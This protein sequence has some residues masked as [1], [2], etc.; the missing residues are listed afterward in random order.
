VNKAATHQPLA[1]GLHRSA[2][3][4]ELSRRNTPATAAEHAALLNRASDQRA[5]AAN[6]AVLLH[7]QRQYGNNYVNQVLQQG[8]QRSIPPS[9]PTGIQTK[10][11]IGPAGDKYEREADRVAAAVVETINTPSPPAAGVGP[12][13]RAKRNTE[14]GQQTK[15][16]ISSLQREVMPDAEELRAQMKP[17]PA[18]HKQEP[19]D[20]MLKGL[21][22]KPASPAKI[23]HKEDDESKHPIQKKSHPRASSR[24]QEDH[25]EDNV[26]QLQP[27]ARNP[28]V[29]GLGEAPLDLETSI[30]DV[31]GRGRPLP[32][33]IRAPMEQ[34]FGADFSGVKVHTDSHADYLNRAIQARAF[35]TGQ[36]VFFRQGEFALGS[37]RGQEL[38]AH[39][40]THVVQQNGRK[41]DPNPDSNQ[42]RNDKQLP[43]PAQ[44]NQIDT[45]PRPAE[46]TSSPITDANAAE[47]LLAEPGD[48][49]LQENE[50]AQ[51]EP[52]SD[53][54]PQSAETDP[55]FQDVVRQ[56]RNVATAQQDHPPATIKSSE[57]Q[58][59]AIPPSNEVVSKAQDK[60]VDEMEQAQTP[61]FNAEDFKAALKSRLSEI[62]P[63]DLKA[64][65][66]FKN[67]NKLESIK[68]DV[69]SKVKT[70]EQDSKGPLEE[71]S[72]QS[73]DISG[74]PAKPVSP[75]PPN[76]PGDLP[77]I[78]SPEQAAPKAKGQSEVEGP[79]IA[80]SQALDQQL[81]AAGITEEQLLKSNEPD[82]QAALDSKKAAQAHSQIA[83][84]AYR[85][86]EHA[87][88]LQAQ[89]SAASA[90]KDK[91]QG[92]HGS[93]S[94]ALVGVTGRQVDGKGRDEQKRTRIADDIDKIYQDTKTTVDTK[95]V[96]LS[97][98]VIAAF[99]SGAANAK[100][101]FERYVA[102]EMEAYKN[103]RYAE[104]GPF[105]WLRWIADQFTGLPAEV[106]RFYE[107]GRNQ[108]IIIMDEVIEKVAIIV[109]TGLNDAMNEVSKG[110]EQIKRYVASLPEDLRQIGVEAAEGIQ[111]QFDGLQQ[112]V[113][114][115]QDE[116]VGLL[117]QKYKENL[118]AIDARI[119]ELQEA[120]KGLIQ[121][122]IDFIVGVITTIIEL[123]KLLLQ[124]LARVAASIGKILLDPIGFLSNLFNALKQGFL[125]FVK[126]IAK[127][128]SQGLLG[129][130]T[131]ALAGVNI[132]MPKNLEDTQGIFGMV[133]GVLGIT[134][135][136]IRAKAVRR[137]GRDGEQKASH[138]EQSLEMFRILA[139][140]GVVGVWQ[141]IKDRLG[142][143]K[144]MV[145]DP[146]TQFLTTT[147]IEAGVGLLIGM[148]TPA[149]SFIRACK[150]I[151]DI[152][153]FVIER[154]QQII[155]LINSILDAVGL[156]ADG[157]IEQAS[158]KVETTLAEAIPLAIG[159][160]ASILGLGD[161]GQKVQ[162]MLQKMRRP[163][164]RAI[165]WVI[166]Q[167][168]KAYRNAGKKFNK[169][170]VSRR[171]ANGN[172]KK[173][174][175]G[176]RTVNNKNSRQIKKSGNHRRSVN[177]PSTD[178]RSSPH[179]Q[180]L[181]EAASKMLKQIAKK[182]K[183]TADVEKHFPSLIRKF[184]LKRIEWVNLGKPTACIEFE[185]NP[186]GKIFNI[187][188]LIHIIA[189]NAA[190]E[191]DQ[192]TPV[193]KT[194]QILYPEGSENVGVEMSVT[195]GP[196]H[197]HKVGTGGPP[198]VDALSGLFYYLPTD[199]KLK[200]NS[201][202]VKGH[203]LNHNL[204]G[205]G[206]ADNLFPITAQANKEH[207]NI[208]EEYV[209]DSVSKGYLVFYH[210]TILPGESFF[211]HRNSG[212]I[213]SIINIIVG[214]KCA[215]GKIQN[216]YEAS[217]SSVY[218]GPR[219]FRAAKINP[220]NKVGKRVSDK[221]KKR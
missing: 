58:A 147:V 122:A 159:F 156:V 52:A 187:T 155:A 92:M 8:Q 97:T 42:N 149:S 79:A 219:Q 69:T 94:Q 68:N 49:G 90:S 6:K 3:V 211:E 60:Q 44:S 206:T 40:L 158:L 95:L 125:N 203:L 127:Y 183:T 88:I 217:F 26:A 56:A 96:Q 76:P 157:A 99:D 174:S 195:L 28:H 161:I 198:T 128:L 67:S 145:L 212:W 53:A 153:K 221:R 182:S 140:Q 104:W 113:Q 177:K 201:K 16:Q 132:Q 22:M 172:K 13:V 148:M 84:Q 35:T 24:V 194:A 214:V 54:A 75:L 62:T 41:T 63:K 61:T 175:K 218:K 11:T 191:P 179:K 73:P 77:S 168:L 34:A 135:E 184:S 109:A 72:S 120:N 143:L 207:L 23:D 196:P 180:K 111:S 138:L 121:K 70:A 112:A 142:D 101:F 5:S 33:H 189:P 2:V 29:P 165:D 118:D 18:R 39:E 64:A 215:S 48:A 154:A 30:Q 31:R 116:L 81:S 102:Q 65:E 210:V 220:N 27:F 50:A 83:P 43:A 1:S 193:L 114:N 144:K 85:Q 20:E 190:I 169:G 59:A 204:G 82:F 160:M 119:K 137:L 115:H 152:L 117:A 192:G 36:E 21:Q 107:E 89:A 4:Q 17:A 164:D 87:Q 106:N 78:I 98:D 51:Q 80:R 188:N 7:L 163:I 178:N 171:L 37:K 9:S 162:A 10:L 74:I 71:K 100:N 66:D 126:N 199:P 103:K 151:Y 131:G 176:T 124:V 170:K 123:G 136:S 166:D 14:E 200:N 139:T 209:K 57:A 105:G 46:P 146:I 134:Y 55:G 205:P 93:R 47:D 173:R 197:R 108:Y 186:K 185:I 45:P 213:N 15:S 208:A 25:E 167:G 130:L 129:W 19:E 38:L 150:A 12:S 32:T 91:L 202:F 141:V 110:R 86:G 181:F 216:L 133:M